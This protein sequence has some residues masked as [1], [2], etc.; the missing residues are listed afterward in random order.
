MAELMS[1]SN[2]KFLKK[3]VFS[4]FGT[5]VLLVLEG[6]VLVASWIIAHWRYMFYRGAGK[7]VKVAG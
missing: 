7:F 4:F 6:N 5:P 1:F 3:K 2:I